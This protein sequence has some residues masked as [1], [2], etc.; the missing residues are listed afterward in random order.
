MQ[1]S[2]AHAIGRP[3]ARHVLCGAWRPTGRERRL[4]RCRVSNPW[5]LMPSRSSRCHAMSISCAVAARSRTRSPGS[6][7]IVSTLPL[8]SSVKTETAPIS[9]PRSPG[10][11]RL[12]WGMVT[13]RSRAPPSRTPRHAAPR[14]PRFGFPAGREVFGYA[15]GF[16]LLVFPMPV[17]PPFSVFSIS[18][19]ALALLRILHACTIISC[20]RAIRESS[21]VGQVFIFVQS[22]VSFCLHPAFRARFVCGRIR[23]GGGG[24]GSHLP[25]VVDSR[26]ISARNSAWF[27]LPLPSGI[28]VRR[29][30]HWSL[31]QAG[32]A[33]PRRW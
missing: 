27:S 20:S 30:S 24:G 23:A 13:D 2:I 5:R 8:P 9:V 22:T 32:M 28:A 17:S 1:L 19:N 6:T 33:L 31:Q 12:R 15:L 11:A 25:P 21:F 4:S 29:P 7:L 16:A 18:C 3:H 14:L 10:S 26:P